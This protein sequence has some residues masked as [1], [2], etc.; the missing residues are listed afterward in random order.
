MEQELHHLRLANPSDLDETYK[1]LYM[2]NKRERP[3]TAKTY[4]IILS[5]FEPLTIKEVAEAVSVKADGTTLPYIDTDYIRRRCRNFVI[6]NNDGFLEFA[7]ESAR[8]FL[9]NA[10][11]DDFSSTASHQEMAKICLQ[12]MG[13]CDHQLWLNSSIEPAQWKRQIYPSIYSTKENVI[14]KGQSVTLLR[15]ILSRR[16]FAQYVCLYW[17]QHCRKLSS[18]RPGLG[19]KLS[20]E[21]SNV[22]LEPKTVFSGWC[23]LFYGLKPKRNLSL[24]DHQIMLWNVELIDE[25]GYH[26]R[27][28]IAGL[29]ELENQVSC[30]MHTNIS[31]DKS[32][33]PHPLLAVC[34]WDFLECLN[35]PQ[36][37][38]FLRV[39][40]WPSTPYSPIQVCSIQGSNRALCK[41]IQEYPEKVCEFAFKVSVETERLPIWRAI[42][43]HDVDMT[44]TLLRLERDHATNRNCWSSVQLSSLDSFGDLIYD[45][46]NNCAEMV[47]LLLEFEAG[48]TGAHFPPRQGENWTSELLRR[49]TSKS[50]LFMQI[51]ECLVSRLP[52]QAAAHLGNIE[53]VSLLLDAGA[54]SSLSQVEPSP[55]SLALERRQWDEQGPGV[56]DVLLTKDPSVFDTVTDDDIVSYLG[57]FLSPPAARIILKKRPDFAQMRRSDGKTALMLARTL[58]R[59]VLEDESRRM[60]RQEVI[61]LLEEA[62][63]ERN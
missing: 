31:G 44:R 60:Q 51:N 5:A 28:A 38:D 29:M 53:V 8:L 32:F 49:P 18:A 26:P 62:E 52:L 6:E 33:S 41:L 7:H 16:G 63:A 61:R 40:D 57:V 11:V 17:V 22:F 46:L 27:V 35:Q 42:M 50:C 48:Q 12:L 4:R 56:V 55:L 58:P 47:R 3:N 39:A 25:P 45:T 2:E 54:R 30:C 20:N 15:D 37:H 1:R 19:E 14:V 59:F 21:L 34:V 36:F 13:R 9:E 43:H 24:S 10:A 23:G